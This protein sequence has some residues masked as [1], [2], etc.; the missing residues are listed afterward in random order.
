MITMEKMEKKTQMLADMLD[1][2]FEQIGSHSAQEIH[3]DGLS[4]SS[5]LSKKMESENGFELSQ[6]NG[7]SL[8]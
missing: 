6:L 8:L 2:P 1:C 7:K 3:S 4:E 5:S